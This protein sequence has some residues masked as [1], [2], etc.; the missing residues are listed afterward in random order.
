M[1]AI[2]RR[3]GRERAVRPRSHLCPS[4]YN[5]LWLRGELAAFGPPPLPPVE[6]LTTRNVP[7]PVRV[8][9]RALVGQGHTK[10]AIAD[11]YGIAR[12]TVIKICKESAQ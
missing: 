3:C 5:R 1:I 10:Q 6:P 9:I 8:Q 12:M 4:C 11:A 2:C 7:P